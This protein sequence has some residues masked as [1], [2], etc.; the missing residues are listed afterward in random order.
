MRTTNKTIQAGQDKDMEQIMGNLLRIGVILAAVV[1]SAGGIM[2]LVLHGSEVQPSYAIFK[3]V[4]DRYTSLPAVL[5]GVKELNS[6]SIM[7][8]GILILIA[9]PIM[10][11]L[12]SI[13]SFFR[14]KDYLYVVISAIVLLI[15]A[16]SLF[17]GIG[18]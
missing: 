2:Y 10:R 17:N 16:F 5:R 7:Q 18:A 8:L 14:E 15:I 1:A 4:S 12:F 6:Y 13:F 9:T 11:I 3:G